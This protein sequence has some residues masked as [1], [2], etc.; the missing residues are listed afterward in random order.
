MKKNNDGRLFKVDGKSR[1]ERKKLFA[2]EAAVLSVI[3]TA[4]DLA[5]EQFGSRA[6]LRLNVFITPGADILA[7]L[8][9]G[10]AVSFIVLYIM[11]YSLYEGLRKIRNRWRNQ[12][13]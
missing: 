12:G 13:S 5:S 3:Y 4:M 11:D 10:F 8:A 2:T 1:A 6:V 7:S 9:A